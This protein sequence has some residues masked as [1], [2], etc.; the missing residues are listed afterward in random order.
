M[1][2]LKIV[3][4]GFGMLFTALFCLLASRTYAAGL[5]FGILFLI[6]GFALMVLGLFVNDSF[7]D[8]KSLKPSEKAPEKPERKPAE[9]KKPAED[10]E[11]A[12]K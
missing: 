1:K 8:L 7:S 3:I 6:V 10:K 5:T 11:K 12:G 2:G 9:S 4:C